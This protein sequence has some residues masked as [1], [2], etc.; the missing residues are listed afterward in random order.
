MCIMG[1]HVYRTPLVLAQSFRKKIFHF[2]FLFQ[3]FIYLNLETKPIIVFQ[4]IILYVD[5]I[6][7][8]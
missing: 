2:N 1:S 3:L 8:F 4:G 5:N 7:A 6:I